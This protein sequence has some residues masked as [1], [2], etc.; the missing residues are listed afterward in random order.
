MCEKEVL[1]GWID[2]KRR[3]VRRECDGAD[4]VVFSI[5]HIQPVIVC[6]RVSVGGEEVV[7]RRINGDRGG[8]TAVA[9]AQ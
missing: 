4:E 1:R 3:R 5:K 7:R 8:I 9:T 2:D 6:K